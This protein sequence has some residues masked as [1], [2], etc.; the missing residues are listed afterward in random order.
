MS[1]KTG[2]HSASRYYVGRVAETYDATR[3]VKPAWADEHAAVAKLIGNPSTVLDAPVGT[4]RFA[5]LYAECGVRSVLGVDASPDMLK[6][7]RAAMRRH[8][9]D[10]TLHVHDLMTPIPA[11]RGAFEVAIMTRFLGLLFEDEV[12]VVLANV[13]AV[14]SRLLVEV[15]AHRLDLRAVIPEGARITHALELKAAARRT[16]IYEVQA[17]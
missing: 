15:P 1:R 12:P 11:E 14:S 16:V 6:R 9:I 2:A 17:P 10:C 5:P 3:S 7:A 4:G 13:L 8:R